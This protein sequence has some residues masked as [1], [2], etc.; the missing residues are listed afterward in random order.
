[1]TDTIS[2]P[3][4][5]PIA[6]FEQGGNMPYTFVADE[7]FPLKSYL[8]RPF[9]GRA[10]D[11]RK[12]IYNYRLSRARRRIE[13]TFGKQLVLHNCLNRIAIIMINSY[14][15]LFSGIL[16]HRWK[17]LLRMMQWQP[18]KT[19]KL[20]KGMCV[21]HNYLRTVGDQ[22]YNQP[23]L[24]DSVNQDGTIT[25]GFWRTGTNLH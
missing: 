3:D 20:I 17:L 18:A 11:D 24:A 6:N 1:V 25:P 7:A 5:E 14:A 19:T 13:N 2:I 21:L 4:P 22:R 12:R 15:L 23:G 10:L 8:M 9:P 16:T